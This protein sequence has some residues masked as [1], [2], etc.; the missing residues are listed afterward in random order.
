M[1][2]REFESY[3]YD[4]ED[5]EDRYFDGE[6][7]DVDALYSLHDLNEDDLEDLEEF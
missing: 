1:D 2:D 4:D 3:D 7:L 5:F 6:D